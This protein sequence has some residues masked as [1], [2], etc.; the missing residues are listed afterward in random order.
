MRTI[1]QFI[2][3]DSIFANYVTDTN[4]TTGITNS[5]YKAIFPMNQSFRNVTRVYFKSVELPIGFSNIRKGSTDTI[6]FVLNGTTYNIILPEKNYTTMAS[7][8]TDLNNYIGGYTLSGNATMILSVWPALPNRLM[9]YL[10]NTTSFKFIDTN[11]S[12]YIL[13]IRSADLLIEN[14]AVYAAYSG[15]N[16]NPDNYI[17]AYIPTLNGINGCQGWSIG[18]FKIPMNTIQGQ[19]YF[20]QSGSSFEQ[21]VDITNPDLVITNLEVT[22]F[23]RYG[24]NLNPT[25]FDYSFTLAFESDK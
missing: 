18:T 11:L 6:T 14:A 2:H 3:F 20:Y 1:T 25:G 13:G 24:N 10:T 5:A 4:N 17:L 23:D 19:V 12:K 21:F 9:I 7:L 8:L 16:L 22:L 15:F